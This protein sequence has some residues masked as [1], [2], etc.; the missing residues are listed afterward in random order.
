VTPICGLT[1]MIGPG[2]NNVDLSILKNLS[3]LSGL[4][5]LDSTGI[6]QVSRRDIL[7]VKD[8]FDISYFMRYHQYAQD[9]NHDVFTGIYN[10][11][12]AVH[13]RAATKG[14][15][16]KANAHPFEFDKIIGMHNGTIYSKYHDDHKTD[17][18]LF[19]KDIND[20]GLK[21]T[22]GNLYE[23]DAYALVIYDKINKELVITRNQ[24]RSLYY[25]VNAKRKV[26][27]WASEE[28]MLRTAI[29]RNGEQILNNTVWEFEAG[30]TYKI[31]PLNFKINDR[32]FLK[33]KFKQ[34]KTEKEEIKNLPILKPIVLTDNKSKKVPEI[35]CVSCQKR[36]KLVDMYFGKSIS[37]DI[38]VCP[39]CE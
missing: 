36:L 31:D 38:I 26:I 16:I 2:I 9:G 27:Y 3:Y 37:T 7:V 10:H 1:G 6:L 29:Y 24:H 14:K 34:K 15:V 17:S 32:P 5:G 25:A 23:N 18:E 19:L 8:A 35:Y 39:E 4:R 28:W 22:I 12:F 33:F 30:S 11:L 13:V 20:L 21:D